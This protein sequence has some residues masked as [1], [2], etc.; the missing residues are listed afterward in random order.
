MMFTARHLYQ[1][2]H[3]ALSFRKETF[4]VTSKSGFAPSNII[5]KE[6]KSLSRKSRHLGCDPR[7]GHFRMFCLQC[8]VVCSTDMNRNKRNGLP[9]ES[10]KPQHL[11]PKL[12]EVFLCLPIPVQLNV[13]IVP[14]LTIR[15][16]LIIVTLFLDGYCPKRSIKGLNQMLEIYRV[17]FWIVGPCG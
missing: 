10:K 8:Q 17:V 11:F 12:F 14:F 3:F 7:G 6:T 4:R 1:I 13:T 9:R 2:L 16:L 5:R 15:K